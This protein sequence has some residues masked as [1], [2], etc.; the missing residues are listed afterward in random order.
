MA[1]IYIVPSS[2][3]VWGG[4]TKARRWEEEKERHLR[5]KE[6][7]EKELSTMGDKIAECD[8]NIAEYSLEHWRTA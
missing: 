8:Q 1:R 7:I 2:L 3:F 5:R 6:K 4:I